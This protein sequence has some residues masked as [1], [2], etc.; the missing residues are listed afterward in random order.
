MISVCQCLY[1]VNIEVRKITRLDFK[2]K[3]YEILSTIVNFLQQQQK[4][5]NTN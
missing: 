3:Q 1:S 2:K 4:K 5:I